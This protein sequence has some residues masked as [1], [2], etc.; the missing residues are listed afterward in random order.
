MICSECGRERPGSS[1][2]EKATGLCE[3]CAVSVPGAMSSCP[4][5]D[6]GYVSRS[7]QLFGEWEWHLVVAGTQSD[8]PIKYCPFF[9][10]DLEAEFHLRLKHEKARMKHGS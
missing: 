8:K 1:N 6:S 5:C 2:L 10:C 7:E 4:N 9:G 3:C